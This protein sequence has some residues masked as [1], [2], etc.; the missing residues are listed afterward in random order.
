MGTRL[1]SS[2]WL[3]STAKLFWHSTPC[4]E[5]GLSPSDVAMALLAFP[6]VDA[7]RWYSSLLCELY[8]VCERTVVSRK[9]RKQRTRAR[10]RVGMQAQT[11]PTLISMKD[12]LETFEFFQ[13]GLDWDFANSTREVRRRMLT[14][15]TLG[16]R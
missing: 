5:V 1:T 6:L 15:V 3:Y 8:P 13:V 4:G 14:I 10:R 2:S 12:Q 7:C 16:E 9:T 11:T